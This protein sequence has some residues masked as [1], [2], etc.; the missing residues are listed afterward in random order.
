MANFMF[1]GDFDQ[2]SERTQNGIKTNMA[3]RTKISDMYGADA[4]EW[5]EEQLKYDQ[6]GEEL[7]IQIG[8]IIGCGGL[9]GN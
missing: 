2:N 7:G 1:F 9:R 4:K 8:L 3:S 5:Q 6:S